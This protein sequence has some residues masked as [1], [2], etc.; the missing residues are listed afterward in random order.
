[1]QSRLLCYV[2]VWKGH[3]R[4]TWKFRNRL[5][6]PGFVSRRAKR[7]P[8]VRPWQ[9]RASFSGSR[10]RTVCGRSGRSHPTWFRCRFP[11]WSG[12]KVSSRM[13]IWTTERAPPDQA[14]IGNPDGMMVHSRQLKAAEGNI[15]ADR[16]LI[17]ATCGQAGADHRWR[18][19]HGR[20]TTLFLAAQVVTSALIDSVPE[21]AATRSYRSQD[22]RRTTSAAPLCSWHPAWRATSPARRRM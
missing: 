12:P 2:G 16:A 8:N 4:W 9:A 22:C 13:K 11:C 20:S 21:R 6:F 1:M 10:T 17:L 7:L 14:A 18:P 5:T 15:H 3:L 19:G